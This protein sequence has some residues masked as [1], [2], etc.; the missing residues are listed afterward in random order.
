M[1]MQLEYIL[2]KYISH[3]HKKMAFV[4]D[5]LHVL[6]LNGHAEKVGLNNSHTTYLIY[7]HI[8]L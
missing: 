8:I 7:S 2:E 5:K 3:Q 4:T 6:I 1:A